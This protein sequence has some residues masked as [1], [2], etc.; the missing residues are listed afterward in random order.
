MITRLA[1]ASA[2]GT[3]LIPTH[4]SCLPVTSISTSL[5]SVFMLLPLV[6]MLDVG[7]I[8]KSTFMTSPFEM[9]PKIPPALF[10]AKP[11]DLISSLASEPF[12]F[13]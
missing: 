6:L 2:I 8:I 5:P 3:A 12:K 11:S 4:G 1:I 13:S 7:F 9:P 10:E